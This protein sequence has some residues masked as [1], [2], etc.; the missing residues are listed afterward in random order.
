MTKV[1]KTWPA[2][3][4]ALAVG[5]AG[6][7][8][9]VTNTPTG[10]SGGRDVLYFSDSAAGLPVM[11]VGEEYTAD[12]SVSG[13][14]GPY[15]LKVAGGKLPP[16]IRLSGQK[17]TGTPTATGSYQF[18]L[19]VTD[20]TLS[21]RSKEYTL[22]VNTLP[23]LALVPTL[24]T[25]E[26]R[27][28]TRI[29][30]M[31]TAPRTVRAA[32]L[33]WELPAGTSVTRVQASEQNSVMFWQQT[34]QV[35]TLD[36]GFKTIPRTG[37]RVALITV[38]PDKDKAALLNTTKLGYEARDGTGKLLISRTMAGVVRTS[39]TATRDGDQDGATSGSP[40]KA[41]ET[42]PAQTPVQSPAENSA[43]NPVQSPANPVPTPPAGS[44]G[45]DEKPT[46]P[47]L[48]GGGEPGAY[49]NLGA[50]L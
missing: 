43:Q 23:P 34:G 20:S 13:G 8:Q 11:Y 30:L 29:P 7:G 26:I 41:T 33:S 18:S 21:T 10:S 44:S 40:E 5:V 45:G 42:L 4:L 36:M 28:E 1:R 47:K 32:Q 50:P 38:K 24:P 49:L 9:P 25:G 2:L 27:G 3:A 48:P 39:D 17:L 22:N 12:L 16:G 6:C 19:E 37:V 46:P 35:L 31:I 14:A 15:S